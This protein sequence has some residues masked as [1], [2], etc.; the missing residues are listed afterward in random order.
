MDLKE[1]DDA[2]LSEQYQFHG[3]VSKHG[4]AG[5]FKTG[6][7]Y[8]LIGFLIEGAQNKLFSDYLARRLMDFSPAP[9]RFASR[10]CF[11]VL[12]DGRQIPQKRGGD[13]RMT[14]RLKEPQALRAAFSNV[15]SDPMQLPLQ[16]TGGQPAGAA[17]EF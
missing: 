11:Y 10:G 17:G 14:A 13:R 4:G 3:T 9:Y 2:P 6:P 15:F 5:G 7:E 8:V 16:G 12:T 1:G